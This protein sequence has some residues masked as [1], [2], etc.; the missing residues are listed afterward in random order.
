MT[1]WRTTLP[2]RLGAAAARHDVPGVSVAVGHGGDLIEAAVGVL[3][4]DTGAEVT[5]DSLFH[6]GSA[7]KPWTAALVLQNWRTRA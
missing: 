7:T 5:T 1:D 4:R 3:D 6:T 2:D